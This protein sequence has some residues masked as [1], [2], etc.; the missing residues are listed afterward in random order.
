MVN[1]FAEKW[2]DNWARLYVSWFW[3]KKLPILANIGPKKPTFKLFNVLLWR[4]KLVLWRNKL[5]LCGVINY[6]YYYTSNST[7]QLTNQLMVS[8]LFIVT[9]K[10]EEEERGPTNKDPQKDNDLSFRCSNW[11][12]CTGTDSWANKNSNLYLSKDNRMK[13]RAASFRSWTKRS[14]FIQSGW[15]G[16]N[17]VKKQIEF[18]GIWAMIERAFWFGSKMIW[19][20]LILI[21]TGFMCCKKWSLRS[22]LQT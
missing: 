8:S 4:N 16:R 2:F 9:T 22:N 20:G 21:S 10:Q 13:N 12:S 7:T 17:K 6:Y 19:N 5:L 18:C 1:I 11:Y 3:Y 14:L 15:S